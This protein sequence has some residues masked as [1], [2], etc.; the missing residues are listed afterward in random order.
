MSLINCGHFIFI[1]YSKILTTSPKV[2]HARY[3][4]NMDVTQRNVGWF[5]ANLVTCYLTCYLNVDLEMLLCL[6]CRSE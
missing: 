2:D 3:L 4:R 5:H 1:H 6:L